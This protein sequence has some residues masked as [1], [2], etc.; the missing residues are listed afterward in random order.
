[1]VYCGSG[2]FFGKVLVPVPT[3]VPVPVP[4]P[5]LFSIVFNNKK[6]EQNLAFSMLEAAFFL[7][8]WHIFLDFLTF[9]LHFMLDLGPNPVS[10]PDPEYIAVPVSVPL[11]Q[12]VAIPVPTPISQ[13]YR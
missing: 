11:R 10:G 7:E 9:V 8:N 3:P 6:F 5:V 13:H 2:S 4:D 1:M 12:K